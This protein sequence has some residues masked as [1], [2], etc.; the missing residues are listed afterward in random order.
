MNRKN[1]ILTSTVG[2]TREAWLEF[3]KPMTHVK[4]FI[5]EWLN[6]IPAPT[7][8]TNESFFDPKNKGTYPWLKEL[9]ST[10]QW[11]GFQFPCLGASEVS[12]V[13]GLNPY[14][15]IIELYYEKIGIKD[16]FDQDN[17]AMFWGRELE[18]QVC[19]KWQYWDGNVEG[20]IANFSAKNIVRRCRRINSYAQNK[21]FPWLFVSLDRVIN[22]TKTDKE[23][24]DEGSLEGKT[25][26]GYAADMWEGG[27]PP[28]Y[29]AQL[30]T[31]ILV[32]DFGFGEIA[33]LKDGRHFDVIPFDK[34]EGI[35]ESVKRQ[36]K[37]FFDKVKVGIE[38]YLLYLYCPDE[39][40][41]ALHYAECERLAPEPDGSVAYEKYLSGAY[42]D[43]NIGGI[44]GGSV[45]LELARQYVF[46]NGK[47]KDFEE[48]KR[49]ASN[50]LKGFLGDH[51]KID[52]GEDGTVTWKEASNGVRSMRVN[53]KMSDGWV[54]EAFKPDPGPTVEAKVLDHNKKEAFVSREE[55]AKQRKKK[56]KDNFP[57]PEVP[58]ETPKGGK[59]SRKAVS[60][61]ANR[62]E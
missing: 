43:R 35:C 20:M 32:F 41:K 9:F 7:P 61:D 49:E 51:N 30:Q 25:I 57:A 16:V 11:K 62:G 6:V 37:S 40:Q 59:R 34:H 19:E 45:E 18:E 52:L 28:M 39:D 2:M 60:E 12:T 58:F 44:P 8:E 4:K 21:A 1:L 53:V 31:Q 13:M 50:K 29:V 54:P 27:I 47:L 5:I 26:S 17:A 14:K 24:F 36:S 46:C 56:Q 23:V 10:D 55:G 42:K 48:I 38:N 15:S 22:K 33:I 3:R